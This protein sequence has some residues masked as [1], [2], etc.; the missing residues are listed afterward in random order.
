MKSAS[1]IRLTDEMERALMIQALEG[2]FQP[3]PLRAIKA[4]LVKLGHALQ[5]GL[6]RVAQTRSQAL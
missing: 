1:D 2:P 5:S 4:A 3:Q 6:S